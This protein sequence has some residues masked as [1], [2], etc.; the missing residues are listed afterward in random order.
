MYRCCTTAPHRFITCLPLLQRSFPGHDSGD[1]PD[2]PDQSGLVKSCSVASDCLRPS[3][4]TGT[5]TSSLVHSMFFTWSHHG[6]TFPRAAS[7]SHS[8]SDFVLDQLQP[9]RG[10]QHHRSL[11]ELTEY[12]FDSDVA[13]YPHPST[14]TVCHHFKPRFIARILPSQH[15][16]SYPPI[17]FLPS[18]FAP[19][20]RPTN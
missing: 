6:P 3:R 20:A 19:F 16:F 13:T 15:V 7:S 4:A 1:R 9:L 12:R 5:R 2:K 8:S 18:S 11:T 14:L 10:D 17:S